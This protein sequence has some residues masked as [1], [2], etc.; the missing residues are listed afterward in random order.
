MPIRRLREAARIHGWPVWI[1]LRSTLGVI[2]VLS[3]AYVLV[4]VPLRTLSGR[5]IAESM[6]EV[7]AEILLVIIVLALR[8]AW[9]AARVRRL[10]DELGIADPA[11]ATNKSAVIEFYL[12]GAATLS[13]AEVG[14]TLSSALRDTRVEATSAHQM[15][16]AWKRGDGLFQVSLGV[17]DRPS[18]G[19]G[20]KIGVATADR[21]HWKS[22]YAATVYAA[23]KTADKLHSLN[24]S[25]QGANQS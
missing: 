15:S 7:L 17:I 5:T 1:E 8:A 20:L 24:L 18:E 3:P 23:K 2:A 25:P 13:I 9:I 6:V 12:A 16:L 14:E 19:T 21:G 11:P 10:R 4:V 22:A